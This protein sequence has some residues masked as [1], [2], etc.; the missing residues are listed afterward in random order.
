VPLERVDWAPFDIVSVDLYRSREIADRFTDG[1]RTLV[2]Q[3]KPVAITEFGA[4][5]YR[6]AADLGARALEVLEYDEAGA[7]VRL[8][9]EYVRDEAGQAGYLRELLEVFDAEGVDSAFVFAFALNGLVH[10]PDGEAR[11]DLDLPATASSRCSTAAPGPPT[12]T[13]RGSRRPR[14]PRS[15]SRTGE[16]LL[17]SVRRSLRCGLGPVRSG[18]HASHQSRLARRRDCPVRGGLRRCRYR[19]RRAARPG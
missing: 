2:A 6:G 3:G 13:C 10:R 12:R 19:C 7:P 15:P 8:N 17:V 14:S 18:R 9:G 16:R 4:A 5:T 11:D 1:V